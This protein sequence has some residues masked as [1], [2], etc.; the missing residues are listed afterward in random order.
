MG[1]LVALYVYRSYLISFL[2]K[3][4]SCKRQETVIHCMIVAVQ[5]ALVYD[6]Q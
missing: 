5:D 4:K 2:N 1:I 6:T 3:A